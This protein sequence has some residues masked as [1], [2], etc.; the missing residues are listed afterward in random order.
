MR[1]NFYKKG[2]FN[3]VPDV[4][5]YEV[6]DYDYERDSYIR[7]RKIMFY[8]FGYVLT[9]IIEREKDVQR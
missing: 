8:V 3:I 1:F 4:G 6:Y 5:T 9:V 7:S 2:Y